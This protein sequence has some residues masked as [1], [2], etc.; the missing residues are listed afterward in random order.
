MIA[1][2]AA[3]QPA[4]AAEPIVLEKVC[5]LP[6]RFPV[7]AA[8][9][10]RDGRQVAVLSLAGPYLFDR[11]APGDFK[12]MATTPPRSVVYTEANMEAITF[13]A[14]GLLVTNEKR[15]IFLFRWKDFPEP[16]K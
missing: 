15:A 12:A 4:P 14:D 10:S 5:D 8:D 3:A 6:I 16:K 1:E 9:I 2:T 11:P 7:T 13:T